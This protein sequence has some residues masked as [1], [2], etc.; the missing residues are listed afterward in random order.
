MRKRQ[1]QR[2]LTLE[3]IAQLVNDYEAG[4]SMKEL[5]VRWRLHRATIAIHLRKGG[6]ILRRRGIPKANAREAIELYLQGWSCQKLAK[7]YHCDAETV[8]QLLLRNSVVRRRR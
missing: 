7:L 3:Q 1:A 4:A 5:A 2:R 8:R 6:A